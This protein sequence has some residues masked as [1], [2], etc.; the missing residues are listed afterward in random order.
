MVKLKNG[1]RF[2]CILQSM[3]EGPTVYRSQGVAEHDVTRFFPMAEV[4]YIDDLGSM[5]LPELITAL[6]D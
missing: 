6:A 5:T 2:E 3:K 4:E 1:D